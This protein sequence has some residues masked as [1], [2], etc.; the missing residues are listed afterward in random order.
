MYDVCYLTVL[1]ESRQSQSNVK[2][3]RSLC[4]SDY[5]VDEEAGL[6]RNQMKRLLLTS[7]RSTA[8][9]GV[10]LRQYYDET[11]ELKLS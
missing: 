4:E 7:R 1:R 3:S 9:K 10:Y 6:M 2:Q 5:S 11:T 8:R